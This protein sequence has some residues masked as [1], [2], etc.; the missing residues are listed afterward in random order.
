MNAFLAFESF[1]QSIETFSMSIAQCTQL[2]FEFKNKENEKF[3]S[4]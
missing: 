1:W 4:D 3:Q 2:A